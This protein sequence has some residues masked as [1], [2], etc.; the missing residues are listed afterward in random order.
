[1]KKCLLFFVL[2]LIAV[3]ALAQTQQ[4]YVKTKGR[5]GNDGILIPGTPLSEVLVKI[6]GRNEVMSDKRGGFS[7][8]IPD[9]AFYLE[10]VN[11][12]GYVLSD[13]EILS[14]Q[15]SYSTNKLVITLETKE[16]QIEERME[17]FQKINSAQQAMIAKL[18]EEIKLLK[19]ENK[20]NEEEYG[21][22][23]QEIADLQTESQQLVE[24]MVDR[25]SKID[26]D[27]LSEFDRQI[28][29]YILNGELKKAD[30]LL[31]TKGKLEKR[32][33]KLKK[34]NEAN[35]K[36]REELVKKHKKLEKSES[37]ALQ[38]RDDLAKDFH[39]KYE[40]CEL[41]HMNDS[42][43]YYLEQRVLL[44]TTNHMYLSEAG[45]FICDY[46]GEYDR[47]ISFFNSELR[48][49]QKDSENQD[50]LEDAYN[51]LGHVYDLIGD[52]DR[53]IGFTIKSI[54]IRESIY[55]K[56]NSFTATAYNNLAC[57]YANKQDYQTALSYI[58]QAIEIQEKDPLVTPIQFSTS[59]NT[60]GVIYAYLLDYNKALEYSQKALEVRKQ[61][62][63][64][65]YNIGFI[66]NLIGS[67]YEKLADYQAG[68]E[69]HN[70]AIQVFNTFLGKDHPL[71]AV[72]YS[73]IAVT[74]MDL[75]QLDT[76]LIYL[77][78]AV[79]IQ[80]EMHHKTF[81]LAVTYN[82][83]GLCY[84]ELEQYDKSIEF[85]QKSIDLN[86]SI[87]GPES[88]NVGTDYN[89]MS[90]TYYYKGDP[91]KAL[92][93]LNKAL[94]IYNGLFEQ[95]NDLIADTYGNYGLV[96]EE[97]G[98]DDTALEYYKKAYDIFIDLFGEDHPKT[99]K[100]KKYFE[101]MQAKIAEKGKK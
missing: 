53:A 57:E 81:F 77:N 88:E 89:N 83:L 20:I 40:I 50:A 21:K 64:E 95:E 11:K 60:A 56:D 93:C 13:P 44:D 35:A 16:Q 8:P 74:Y 86:T 96:Y 49:A 15:Y 12:K 48:Q 26:Y 94:A 92:E 19:K 3:S 91:E 80:E 33:E 62:P 6:K 52:Y 69:Y 78:K 17:N 42:A 2:L 70:K 90:I 63:K 82:S 31:N 32:A 5:L 10:S 41:Q 59:Y 67:M 73:N 36:E 54:Q 29:A 7:F 28:S 101:E 45:L 98:D 97:L 85:Q 100:Q 38:E 58:T 65:D 55:G 39:H 4:G 87:F 25:Y 27:L 71:I 75:Q 66:Y 9:K 14:K 34:L 76:A 23:L 51:N 30:S 22:R 24:D 79:E 99:I 1:M 68:I 72:I 37:L 61:Y 47:A 43:A 46:L 84:S 18:R